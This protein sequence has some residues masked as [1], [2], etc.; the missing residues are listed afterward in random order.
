MEVKYGL[1]PLSTTSLAES[2]AA[3]RAVDIVFVHGLAGHSYRT[4]QKDNQDRIGVYWPGRLPNW[5]P[6]ARIF[7]Y[8]WNS[9]VA[10]QGK[11]GLSDIAE[12]LLIALKGRSG[13][14]A[15]VNTPEEFIRS[16][17]RALAD[18]QF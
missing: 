16:Q 5:V 1:S 8:C 9:T 3:D 15:R 6:D 18:W 14:E 12:D 17:R 13:L 7:T 10:F 2:D 4:W 11:K